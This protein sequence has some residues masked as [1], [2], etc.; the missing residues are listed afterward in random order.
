[1]VSAF[2]MALGP[3]LGGWIFDNFGGYAWLYVSSLVIGLG[4]AA[5]ALAFPPFPRRA[6]D[7][8]QPA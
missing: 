2:G 3:L 7:A 1:M 4:A 8:L 5:L 6:P